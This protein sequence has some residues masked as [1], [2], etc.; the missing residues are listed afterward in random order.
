[1]LK[2]TISDEEYDRESWDVQRE[3]YYCQRHDIFYSKEQFG[4]CS[5]KSDDKKYAACLHCPV[6]I[7]ERKDVING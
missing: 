1:M 7:H 6:N 5:L 4:L 3:Y 2:Q